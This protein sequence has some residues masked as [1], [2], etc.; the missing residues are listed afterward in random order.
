MADEVQIG[1]CKTLFEAKFEACEN[2]ITDCK[3]IEFMGHRDLPPKSA[4]TSVQNL[5]KQIEDA[6]KQLSDANAAVQEVISDWL[7]EVKNETDAQKKLGF[8]AEFNNY[9]ARQVSLEQQVTEIYGWLNRHKELAENQR[10]VFA[11]I[12]DVKSRACTKTGSE[13]VTEVVKLLDKVLESAS[14]QKFEI[15][16]E[17]GLE[18]KRF[19]LDYMAFKASVYC[20]CIKDLLDTNE[21][22]VISWKNEIEGMPDAKDRQ[23]ENEFFKQS[24]EGEKGINAQKTIAE[25]VL[26]QLDSVIAQLYEQ[27]DVVETEISKSNQ[28]RSSI[29]VTLTPSKTTDWATPPSNTTASGGGASKTIKDPI[30]SGAI[31]A[32]FANLSISPL[33]LGQS[34]GGGTSGPRRSGVSS[35][36]VPSGIFTNAASAAGLLGTHGGRSAA[37]TAPGHG[38]ATHAS[39]PPTGTSAPSF[40]PK[41]PLPSFSGTPTEFPSFLE[42]FSIAVDSRPISDVEKLYCLQQCLKG[43]A[44]S[45]LEN[46][47]LVGEN[48]AVALETLRRRYGDSQQIIR[49][50]HLQLAKIPPASSSVE[51]ARSTFEKIV[52]ITRQLQNLGEDTNHLQILMPIEAK[53]P[54]FV[55]EQV[56]QVKTSYNT[57][58]SFLP[59]DSRIPWG[60]SHLTEAVNQYLSLKEQIEDMHKSSAGGKP[61]RASDRRQGSG[62][63]KPGKGGFPPT[64]VFFAD[65]TKNK[66]GPGFKQADNKFRPPTGKQKA[67]PRT[68]TCFFCAKNHWASQCEAYPT[69]EDRSKRAKEL[70]LCFRCLMGPH[71]AKECTYKKTMHS[72][73]GFTQFCFL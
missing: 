44:K 16:Q 3:E 25:K 22:R 42:M 69:L 5:G 9:K 7:D 67:I 37:F 13:K 20:R 29:S 70:Q 46:V 61:Q 24:L 64:G 38:L 51:S 43:P 48:Y 35:S 55:L 30:S 47:P 71:S 53:L 40:R 14:A 33:V 23:D 28:H 49:D 36:F 56:L 11:L 39:L 10:R 8:M 54:K 72:L 63:G 34:S 19:R 65:A 52:A 73:L 12:V 18:K 45:V 17:L 21:T 57:S 31:G 58:Q 68:V 27:L 41:I 4:V 2:V 59:P 6:Q 60:L 32:S 62:G 50:L 66:K 15:D 26:Q 1:A